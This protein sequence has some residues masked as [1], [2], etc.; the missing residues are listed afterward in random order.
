METK[1][2]VLANDKNCEVFY[3]RCISLEAHISDLKEYRFFI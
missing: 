3:T 1:S 2:A